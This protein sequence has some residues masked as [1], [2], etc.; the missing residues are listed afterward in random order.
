MRYTLIFTFA[1]RMAAGTDHDPAEVLVRATRKVLASV[2]HI[3]NY[4]CVETVNRQYLRPAANHLP[5]ACAALL[6]VRRHPTLDMV[7]RGFATDRLR[8]DVAMTKT[9]EVF[10]WVGASRFDDVGVDQVVRNGPMGYR[11]FWRIGV[12]DLQNRWQ[13]ILFHGEPGGRWTGPL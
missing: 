7:L 5:R 9:G 12:P 4:T 13:G 11:R 3:P 2:E 1:A 10:S 6:E 8:L